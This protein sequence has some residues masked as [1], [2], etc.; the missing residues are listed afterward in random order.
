MGRERKHSMQASLSQPFACAV[1]TWNVGAADG[2]HVT[3][4]APG[5]D[6]WLRVTSEAPA[7]MHVVALQEV[8]NINNPLSYVGV[9]LPGGVSDGLHEPCLLYTSPSPRD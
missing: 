2:A 1:S 3:T 9:P 4:S 6:Q 5:I 8:I 7:D